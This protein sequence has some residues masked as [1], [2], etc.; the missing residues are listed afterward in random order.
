MENKVRQEILTQLER[1]LV[2]CDKCLKDFKESFDKYP[3]YAFKWSLSAFRAAC[4]KEQLEIVISQ[5][6]SEVSLIKIY[7]TLT[8]DLIMNTRDLT[9]K[10]N[11]QTSNLVDESILEA[12]SRILDIFQFSGFNLE[13]IQGGSYGFLKV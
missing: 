6:N 2:I 7:T 1:K 11:S 4:F 5:I 13:I 10:S 8:S 12:K 3:V 9:N